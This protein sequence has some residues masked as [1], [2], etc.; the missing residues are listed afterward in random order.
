MVLFEAGPG[1]RSGDPPAPSG[2]LQIQLWDAGRPYEIYG[3]PTLAELEWQALPVVS[4]K[5]LPGL[6]A[7]QGPIGRWERATLSFP[8]AGIRRPIGCRLPDAI[9]RGQRN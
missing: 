8:V 6:A 4:K 1:G 7:R 2:G 3:N 5:P 9:L